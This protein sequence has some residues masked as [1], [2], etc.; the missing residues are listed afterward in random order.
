[1]SRSEK[2]FEERPRSR[3]H[4]ALEAL[5]ALR[6]GEV[7]R[8]ELALERP[9][10]D[11]NTVTTKGGYGGFRMLSWG[12]NYGGKPDGESLLHLAVRPENASNPNR[13]DIVAALVQKGVDASLRNENE[14]TAR[15]LNPG[16]LDAAYPVR[17]WSPLAVCA[18][19]T[20]V[21][22]ITA[23]Q[24]PT[25]WAHL[26]WI[27]K[28]SG[29]KLLKISQAHDAFSHWVDDHLSDI[30][31]YGVPSTI[32]QDEVKRWRFAFA[33]LENDTIE[34]TRLRKTVLSR[35]KR[36][37]KK[38]EPSERKEQTFSHDD[39]PLRKESDDKKTEDP[40]GDSP[41]RPGS[42]LISEDEGSEPPESPVI[43]SEDE[44]SD[45]EEDKENNTT[46]KGPLLP[47]IQQQ[48]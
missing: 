33:I 35:K 13:F 45:A 46:R 26:F 21:S 8:L 30:T 32:V 24:A 29:E 43:I 38:L 10:A 17:R 14:E 34:A 40:L 16:L 47:P 44:G 39:D 11:V 12:D 37:K 2:T 23:I 5:E 41:Q 36:A 48:Q 22:K 1:M 18:W 15:D 7:E 31:R 27:Y 9:G 42:P 19:A 20:S 28:I 25:S 3:A 6:G 4:W